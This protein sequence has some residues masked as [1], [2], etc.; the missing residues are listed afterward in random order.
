MQEVIRDGQNG[1]LVDFFSPSALA[2]A[3]ADLLKSP[4]RAAALGRAARETVLKDYS[5]DVCL[6]RQLQL[7]NLVA[8]RS[9]GG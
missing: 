7:I 5:L 6:P 9:I 8:S 4:E 2:E 1:V 3:M